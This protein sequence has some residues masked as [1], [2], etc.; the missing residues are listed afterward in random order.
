M[1]ITLLILGVVIGVAIIFVLLL[2]SVFLSLEEED[3]IDFTEDK[4]EEYGDDRE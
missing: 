4:A 2:L 3:E 1:K